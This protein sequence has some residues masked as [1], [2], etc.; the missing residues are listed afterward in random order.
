MELGSWIVADIL[1]LE[2]LGRKSSWTPRERGEIQGLLQ[3]LKEYT[4]KMLAWGENRG[5]TIK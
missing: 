4:E 2:P 1:S 3:N 5:I